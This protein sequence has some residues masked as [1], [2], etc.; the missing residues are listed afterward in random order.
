MSKI[1][2][3]GRNSNLRGNSSGFNSKRCKESWRM[4][5]EPRW[6]RNSR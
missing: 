3:K 6:R 5:R 4:K 1:E 2:N